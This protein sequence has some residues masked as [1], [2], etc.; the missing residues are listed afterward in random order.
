M[1]RAQCFLTRRSTL[2]GISSNR[3]KARKSLED[4]R[5]KYAVLFQLKYK[6]N[7][8]KVFDLG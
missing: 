4:N 3:L 6:E 5:Q 1:S 7:A 8:E 2:S